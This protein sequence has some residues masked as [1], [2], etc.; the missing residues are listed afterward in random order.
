MYSAHIVLISSSNLMFFEVIRFSIGWVNLLCHRL[1]TP[2]QFVDMRY[3][4]GEYSSPETV[5]AHAI[6]AILLA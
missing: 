5:I 3:Y 6:L 4:A 2:S 1:S